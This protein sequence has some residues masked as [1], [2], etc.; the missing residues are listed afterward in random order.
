MK[1]IGAGMLL[2]P[3]SLL[4]PDVSWDATTEGLTASMCAYTA[5]PS[6]EWLDASG[7]P[8]SEASSLLCSSRRQHPLTSELSQI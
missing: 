3:T 5:Q 6:N 8:G 1:W 2:Y 4:D 7:I